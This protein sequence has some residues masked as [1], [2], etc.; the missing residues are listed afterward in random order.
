MSSSVLKNKKED[1]ASKEKIEVSETPLN[2]G[3]EAQIE[4][5][6][7]NGSKDE[8]EE[9]RRLIV[10]AEEVGEVLPTAVEKRSKKDN[11]LTEAT[12]PIVEENIRQSVLRN[13]RVMAE[14]LFPVIGPAIRKAISQALS[15][16]VQ[17]LN[18]SLEY[19]I[20]PR[21]LSWRLEAFRTGKTFG[22][23]VMLKT[24]LYRVEQVFLI[25]K[26]TGLLLQHVAANPQDTEDADMVSAML[27]AI[28]DFVHDS[29]KT[30]DDAT[31]DSLKIKELS[32]WIES[33]PDAIIA[34][35]IRGNPPLTLREVFVEAIEKIQYKQEEELDDFQGNAEVFAK[36]RPILE[37]CLQFQ[38]SKQ[39][40]KS[41]FL[42]PTTAL[43]GI[44]GLLVLV[45]GFF[46]I[47]DYWRWSGY[48]ENLQ[49]KQGIVVTEAKRG[50]FTH[51]INGLRDPLAPNPSDSLQEFGFDESDVIQN[52]RP[53]QDLGEDFVLRRAEKHLNPPNGVELKFN[54]GVLT[55]SGTF[56]QKWYDESA[57][58]VPALVGVNEFKKG[59]NDLE[60]I[61]NRI[62]S[63]SL[64]FI[65]NTVD[66]ANNQDVKIDKLVQNIEE[67]IN[68]KI[69]F[70]LEI[71]GHANETGTEETNINISDE[72]A[73]K[74]TNELISKSKRIAALQQS[75]PQFI[76]V[77]AEGESQ[78]S[79]TCKVTFEIN[80][81]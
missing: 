70:Q 25:H 20:S 61:K 21:G 36:S 57:K 67:L 51:S 77:I 30:S 53:Y 81:Q 32:V 58:I 4:S 50:W 24:L 69:N 43:L 44:L 2:N 26:E 22:E 40:K 63:Q 18:Q 54:K 66:L 59:R 46:Y 9:L 60:E 10:Q 45:G 68:K 12:L 14:A 8:I 37:E 74:I 6:S 34:A 11:K 76:K 80:P 27:T 42:S 71:H 19:S 75:N 72:R 23:V 79:E 41:G 56:S 49:T 3:N 52:W 29:F 15:S 73:R 7:K 65:C 16:M 39:Q 13:P 31:L 64:L 62:E 1:S 17:N 47:R 55:A 48:I 78:K 33:S 35:V 28:T 5:T 38:S